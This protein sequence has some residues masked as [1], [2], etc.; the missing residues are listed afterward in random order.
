MIH[1][2]NPNYTVFYPKRFLAPLMPAL[3]LPEVLD[4]SKWWEGQHRWVDRERQYVFV[5]LGSP[6]SGGFHYNTKLIDPKE[7]KSFWDFL[8]PKCKERSLL[9]RL[10][11]IQGE[12]GPL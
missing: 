7:F 1:G 12:P 6:S 3:I 8:D 9:R 5:A 4:E 10:E 2:A 11:G